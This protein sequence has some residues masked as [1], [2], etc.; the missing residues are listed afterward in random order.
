MID[1]L[2]VV[3]E[4]GLPTK[5]DAFIRAREDLL[6]DEL[7]LAESPRKRID[8]LRHSVV[9][10]QSVESTV[11][12]V[13]LKEPIVRTV[14]LMAAKAHRL[15]SQLALVQECE[16]AKE[17]LPPWPILA[18]D[19]S[20]ESRVARM[21]DDLP[22]SAYSIGKTERDASQSITVIWLGGDA[23][24]D[25]IIASLGQ[26]TNL[27]TLRLQDTKTSVAAVDALKNELPA[28]EVTRH[29]PNPNLPPDPVPIESTAE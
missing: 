13:N 3:Y 11:I 1:L 7:A 12:R 19:D 25:R 10:M 23:I 21:I 24:D 22:L 26:L 16:A 5:L 18:W 14:E 9:C 15:K 4:V 28:L 29:Q 2:E 27:S 8:V 17:L 20:P 6:T